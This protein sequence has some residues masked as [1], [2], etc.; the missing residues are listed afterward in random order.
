M[1]KSNNFNAYNIQDMQYVRR[2]GE[3]LSSDRLDQRNVASDT[4]ADIIP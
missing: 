4:L 1:D 2:M 3:K